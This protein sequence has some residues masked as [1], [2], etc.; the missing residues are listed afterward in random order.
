MQP[1]SFY[2]PTYIRSL[3]GEEGGE[4]TRKER[5]GH[6]YTEAPIGETKRKEAGRAK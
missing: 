4:G 2:L 1:G 3:E 6:F 5:G